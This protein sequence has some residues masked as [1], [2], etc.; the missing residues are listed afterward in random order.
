MVDSESRS[1]RFGTTSTLPNTPKEQTMNTDIIEEMVLEFVEH[2]RITDKAYDAGI[3]QSDWFRQALTTIYQRGREDEGK[4]NLKEI[5]CTQDI[6]GGVCDCCQTNH[7]R[8]Y[9]K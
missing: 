5:K 8:I 3:R 4:E 7:D 1:D 9:D 6:D 2:F